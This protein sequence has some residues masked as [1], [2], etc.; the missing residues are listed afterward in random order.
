VY[1]ALDRKTKSL[2]ALKK[3]QKS[4]IKSHWMIDQFILEVKLQAYL[5]HPNI[6]SLF[7]TFDDTD[8]VYILLE[9]M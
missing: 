4:V 6:L 9:Y 7:T 1:Q 2:Y 3:V 5:N 8:N